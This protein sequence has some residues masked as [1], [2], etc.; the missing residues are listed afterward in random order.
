MFVATTIFAA[1]TIGLPADPAPETTAPAEPAPETAT[2]PKDDP[3]PKLDLEGL[4]GPSKTRLAVMALSANGVPDDYAVGLTETLATSAS[5]TGVFETI[6][7]K[8]I[9]SL[10]AYEKRKELMGGCVQE[11]C[12]VQIAQVVKADHLLAG[13]VAKVGEK[14]V[15]NLVLIDAREGKALKRSNRETTNASELMSE[16]RQAGIIVLQPV[17]SDR[18]GFLKIA[19]NVTNAQVIID[20]ER[21]SEGV[22]QVIPLAAGP[23]VLRVSRDGFYATSADVFV[24]PGRVT[25]ETIKLIPAK[26]TIDGYETKAKLMRYGG[27]AAGVVAV[28]AAVLSGVFYAQATDDKDVVDRYASALDAERASGRFGTYQQALDA[29]DS[30]DQNQSLYM[31][32]LGTAVVTGAASL[33]LLLSGDDPDRYEEFRS[34]SAE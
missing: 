8:Q 30:F 27:Y 21:R 31:I 19:A 2:A 14:L 16:A 18:R 23:H 13:S 1:L 22:G 9:A 7:P 32:S 15:L 28:G 3:K 5:E 17:L 24:R 11:S 20:D 33:Y 29:R 26:E 4:T 6:S 10:L 25:E 34:L 12:Y